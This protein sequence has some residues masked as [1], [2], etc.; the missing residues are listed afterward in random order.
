MINED[1]DD[2]DIVI[3]TCHNIQAIVEYWIQQN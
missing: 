2:Q 1:K 3:E